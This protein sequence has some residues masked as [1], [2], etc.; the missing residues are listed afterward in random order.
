MP[1][2]NTRRT[3]TSISSVRSGVYVGTS[4]TSSP[5]SISAAASVLSCR[6]LPQ[7]MPAA[8]AAT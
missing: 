1:P 6:Q 5:N 8:P 7:Y 2:K 3:L 4:T